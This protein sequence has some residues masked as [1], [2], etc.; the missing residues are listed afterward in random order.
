MNRLIKYCFCGLIVLLA[1][2]KPVLVESQE[3]NYQKPVPMLGTTYHN[4]KNHYVYVPAVEA[5]I[6]KPKTK[7]YCPEDSAD[8]QCP[9]DAMGDGL[10]IEPEPL[11]E[12]RRVS[13]FVN[14]LG[15]RPGEKWKINK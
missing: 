6:V 5:F 1:Q 11:E 9:V 7:D 15:L 12:A 14:R 10:N 13:Q 8:Y 4:I 3:L 2:F